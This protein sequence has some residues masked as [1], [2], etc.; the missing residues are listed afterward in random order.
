MFI[1]GNKTSDEMGLLVVNYT[2]R[3][4]ARMPNSYISI[5]GRAEPIFEKENYFEP[6][7]IDVE[8]DIMDGSSIGDIFAW[9]HNSGNGILIDE[10]HPDKYRIARVCDEIDTVAVNDEILSITIPFQCS[11]FCYAVENTPV[12]ITA[13]PGYVEIKGGYY[14]E[15]QYDIYFTDGSQPGDFNF[16]VNDQYVT[17]KLTEEHLKHVITLDAASQKIYYKDTKELILPDTYGAIP[18]L[19]FGGFNSIEWQSPSASAQKIVITKN[20]RWL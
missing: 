4:K 20:E 15:P 9:L 8:C 13:S 10:R 19:N 5:P 1:F 6:V 12:E 3:K 14:C 18:F 16:F 7:K 11:A 17:I 2:L